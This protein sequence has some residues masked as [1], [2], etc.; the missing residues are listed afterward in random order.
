[1]AP[2]FIARDL[3]G[4]DHPC[5]AGVSGTCRVTTSALRQQLVQRRAPPRVAQRQLGLDVVEDHV[6]AQRLGQHADLRADVAVAD[7]AERLAA[8]L[9]GV[10]AALLTQP[11]RCSTA[12]FSGMP[13]SSMIDLGQ[14]QLG[15]AARVGEGALNT[16]TPRSRAASE[17]DLVGA[18]AEGA[19]RQQL[20]SPPRA[21]R[22]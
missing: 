6:H 1:M 21:P 14:H 11:P 5:V 9:A 10:V 3:R 18:D 20:A 22:P 2:G 17:V 16:G 19:D 13:R 8:H 12:F 4:A 7:D 15:H